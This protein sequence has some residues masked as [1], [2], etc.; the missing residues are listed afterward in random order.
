MVRRVLRNPLRQAIISG[1]AWLLGAI[2]F[3]ILNWFYSPT[4]AIEI[5]VAIVLGGITTCGLMY[6]LAE[7]AQHPITMRALSTHAPKKPATPGVTAR[8]G[9]LRGTTAGPLLGMVA[10]GAVVLR[11]PSVTT[12]RLALTMIVIGLAVLATGIVR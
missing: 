4:L 7:K 9:H 11:E 10:L 5:F 6:L 1:A 2:G 3:T 8:A 12:E